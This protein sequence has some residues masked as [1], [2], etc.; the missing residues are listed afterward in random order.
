MWRALAASVAGGIWLVYGMTQDLFKR[1]AQWAVV[2]LFV[3]A[4]LV[5]R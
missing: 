3:L 4:L 1:E 2:P 5:V